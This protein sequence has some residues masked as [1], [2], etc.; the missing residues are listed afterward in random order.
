MNDLRLIIQNTIAEAI[1][2]VRFPVVTYDKTTG[3]ASLVEGRFAT[4][5][6]VTNEVS[7]SFE[8]NKHQGRSLQLTTRGWQFHTQLAFHEE[9]SLDALIRL[10]TAV[11]PRATADPDVGPVVQIFLSSYNVSHP[12]QQQPENGTQVTLVFSCLAGNMSSSSAPI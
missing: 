9:V 11:P 2:S 3:M 8:V 10:L 4:P 7:C 6:H 1:N 5:H 12:V